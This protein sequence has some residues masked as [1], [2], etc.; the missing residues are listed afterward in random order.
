MA[1]SG[2]DTKEESKTK[3]KYWDKCYRKDKTHLAQFLHPSD[4]S[5]DTEEEEKMPSKPSLRK[6]HDISINSDDGCDQQKKDSNDKMEVDEE[7]SVEKTTD[8]ADEDKTKGDN[9]DSADEDN[10]RKVK[11]Q[12]WDKCYRKDK[13]H[14]STYIHPGDP[15]DADPGPSKPALIRRTSGRIKPEKKI[16]DGEAVN[17]SGGF[18]LKRNGSTYQCSCFQ[19]TKQ[20]VPT[21]KRTCKHLQ[22]YLGED[23]ENAR[24]GIVASPAKKKVERA[25]AQHI[26]VSVLLAHKY[27]EGDIDPTGWWLSEKLDGVRAYWNGRCFYS[28]LGNAFVAPKWFTKDLPPDMCLDG[29]LFGGRKQFQST[30]SIVKTPDHQHWN[31]IKF[32]VFDIPSMEKEPFEKRMEAVQEYFDKAK[33][34]YAVFVEQSRCKG[35]KHLEEE[36]KKVLDKGGEGLMIRKPKSQYEKTRSHTLLKI[37]KF[38]DA[39][40]RVIGY[41]PGKG[42]NTGLVGALKCVMACGKNF[43][44]GSG[45]TQKDRRNPPK[46]GSIIT[47]K[48]Q[49]LSNSGSP[50]FPTFVGIRIDMNKPKDAEVITNVSDD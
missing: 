1:S 10:P 29:E 23:F 2:T 36:L 28:R 8:D 33:P 18:K 45:L 37:K 16:D 3:C 35:T 32:H 27:V 22:Q 26:H 19:W 6:A 15:E 30:V 20:I 48:F 11:C 24:L 25:P 12:Y 34:Q 47:Y 14:K 41:E 5:D 43:K 7:T 31:K 13:T 42:M 44:V 21:N 9:C 50:R 17:I 38:Y 49:E 46:I 4:K 40:A 39:E